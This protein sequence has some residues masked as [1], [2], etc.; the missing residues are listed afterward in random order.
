MGWSE[1][2]HSVILFN[3]L[4]DEA[5]DEEEEG[6]EEFDWTY[7]QKLPDENVVTAG[8]KY[9]FANNLTGVFTSLQV[10]IFTYCIDVIELLLSKATLYLLTTD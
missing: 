9:G 5:E 8:H 4:G 2:C 7:Q 10:D 1:T 3:L 6:E